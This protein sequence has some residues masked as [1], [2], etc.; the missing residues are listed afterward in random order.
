[1]L[2]TVPVPSAPSD[3]KTSFQ[4]TCGFCGCIFQV[5]ITWRRSFSYKTREE[6]AYDCPECQRRSRINASSTPEVMLIS[7]RTDGRT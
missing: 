1:M 4:Q 7:R 3:G 6:Q 5:G 2:R